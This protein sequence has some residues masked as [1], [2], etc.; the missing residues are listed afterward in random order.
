MKLKEKIKSNPLVEE[1]YQDSDGYWVNLIDG[2]TWFGCCAIRQNTLSR[3]W[4]SLQ[5]EIIKSQN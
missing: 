2:Y 4:L 1:F 3:L 5:H